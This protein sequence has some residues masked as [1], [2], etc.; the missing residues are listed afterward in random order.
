MKY[1]VLNFDKMNIYIT[2]KIH[3]KDIIFH[4]HHP[5]ETIYDVYHKAYKYL[6]IETESLW[7]N[8]F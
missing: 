5:D 1:H 7:N 2:K 6:F 4:I 8:S 3:T